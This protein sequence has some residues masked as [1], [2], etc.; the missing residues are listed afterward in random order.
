MNT[1]RPTYSTDLTDVQWLILAPFVLL[2]SL[3]GRPREVDLRE[4]LNAIFYLLH[5]GCQWRLLPHDFPQW[6]TVYYYYRLWQKTGLWFQ[7]NDTRRRQVRNAAGHQ[8]QPSAAILDSQ[9]VKTTEAGGVCGYDAG[10]KIN[11][12]KRHLRVDTLGLVLMVVVHAANIQDYDGAKLV[13]QH[14]KYRLPRLQLIW[15]D[16]RYTHIIDWMR[17][18]CGWTLSIV[19]RLP[20]T[21]GF[22]VQPH[23]WLIERTFGGFGRERRL[24]KEYEQLTACSEALIY[25]T[26]IRL[27][28]RRLASQD[29]S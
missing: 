12:R 3:R 7:M 21:V 24:S 9:T 15:A 27:R 29:V 19:K 2:P 26:M 5:T 18:Q 25:A 13:M 6:Q 17:V 14:T 22:Q 8:E 28:V 4:V 20:G 23:R 1:P 11:G 10:K 16:S